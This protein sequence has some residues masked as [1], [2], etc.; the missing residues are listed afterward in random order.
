MKKQL[1]IVPRA[2]LPRAR[3][4][5]IIPLVCAFVGG[6]VRLSPAGAQIRILKGEESES[7][8]ACQLLG[9]VSVSSEDALRNTAADLSGDTALMVRQEAGGTYYIRGRIYRCSGD[10]P[11]VPVVPAQIP[12]AEEV[13]AHSQKDPESLRK[14]AKCRDKGG[15]WTGSQCVIEIE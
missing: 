10:S 14:S 1:L 6:C 3:V 12:R 13:S 15:Q 7:V 5:L 4:W 8:S 2:R 11:S 9:Q